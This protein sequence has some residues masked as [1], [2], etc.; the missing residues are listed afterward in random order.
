MTQKKEPQDSLLIKILFCALA[1]I[2]C[3]LGLWVAARYGV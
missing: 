3:L 1:I 2:L